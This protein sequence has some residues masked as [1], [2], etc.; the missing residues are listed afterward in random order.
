[1]NLETF[2]LIPKLTKNSNFKLR[3]S[4]YSTSMQIC[5][6]V[7]RLQSQKLMKLQNHKVKTDK[8]AQSFSI[9]IF[10]SQL[11]MC[12]FCK[13]K[14]LASKLAIVSQFRSQTNLIPRNLHKQPQPSPLKNKIYP[15]YELGRRELHFRCSKQVTGRAVMLLCSTPPVLNYVVSQLSLLTEK[16]DDF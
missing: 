7:S 11:L 10:L 5:C 15:I 12:K 6:Q 3:D 16:N 4:L 14:V 9:C 8:N 13:I 2:R 1:M